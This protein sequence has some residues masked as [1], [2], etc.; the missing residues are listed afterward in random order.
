MTKLYLIR[1]C[2]ALGNLNHL[3]QGS[4]D[5]DI[6]ETGA[7]QLEFLGQRFKGI[8]LDRIYSSPL[9]RTRKTA[10]A[11]AEPKGMDI[12]ICEDLREIDCGVYD[13]KPFTELF[14]NDPE[15][16]EMWANHPQDADIEGGEPMRVS[17]ERIW[18]AVL[19]IVRENRGKTIAAATHGGVTRLLLCRLIYGDIGRLKDTGWTDNTAVT[20]LEFDDELNPTIVFK[21]DAS[22]VPEE[23]MPQASRIANFS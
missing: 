12:E 15:F 16:E 3:L 21:N 22:H 7:K 1:H 5:L 20:L 2:E 6:S 17:Y 10:L 23:Y 14:A 9:I 11:V 19:S 8:H 4:T 18:N 13:G